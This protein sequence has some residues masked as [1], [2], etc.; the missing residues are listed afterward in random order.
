M[1][2]LTLAF[3]AGWTV[4]VSRLP[5]GHVELDWVR[6]G[7]WDPYLTEMLPHEARAFAEALVAV[8]DV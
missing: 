2:Q 5:D 8:R 4:K 1:S 3:D 7:S 6:T